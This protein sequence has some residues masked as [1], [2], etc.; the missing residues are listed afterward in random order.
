VPYVTRE[1]NT[2]VDQARIYKLRWRWYNGG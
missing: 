2:N 1:K